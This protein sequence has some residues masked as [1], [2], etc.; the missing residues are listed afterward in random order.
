MT[1]ILKGT[2]VG[3][4]LGAAISSG[5]HF[6][7]KARKI[8]SEKEQAYPQLFSK[9]D[10]SGLAPIFLEMEEYAM[11]SPKLFKSMLQQGNRLCALILRIAD[12]KVPAK[13]RWIRDTYLFTGRLEDTVKKFFACIPSHAQNDF[14]QSMTALT[15][16]LKSI[17]SN[18][19]KDVTL[20]LSQA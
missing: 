4:V 16:L 6:F 15:E 1:T 14:K 2:L 3:A 17:N 18:N 10:T 19:E 11:F 9:D 12:K 8:P 20:R 5:N 13:I 7:K